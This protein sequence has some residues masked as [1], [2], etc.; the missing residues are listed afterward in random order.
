ML[1]RSSEIPWNGIQNSQIFFY[2]MNLKNLSAECQP[3][4]SDSNMLNTLQWACV[5][6]NVI[7][8]FEIHHY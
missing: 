1:I 3:F 6:I 7:I 2:K 5:W 4:F 8:P